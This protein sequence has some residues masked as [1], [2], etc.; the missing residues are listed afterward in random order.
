MSISKTNGSNYFRQQKHPRTDHDI[1]L[2][3]LKEYK[4]FPHQSDTENCW[5]LCELHIL[6]N[7]LFPD[8]SISYTQCCKTDDV[9][10][11]KTSFYYEWNKLKRWLGIATRTQMK[12]CGIITR[13]H[14]ML[15]LGLPHA[16]PNIKLQNIKQFRWNEC[17]LIQVATKSAVL[18]ATFNLL[19]Y[20]F[21][22]PQL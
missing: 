7:S 4:S 12:L 13:S 1:M 19:F 8:H 17:S 22:F 3:E 9:Q 18:N 15:K 5:K 10:Q 20:N 14:F 2:L 16:Y 21:T 6:S 11:K